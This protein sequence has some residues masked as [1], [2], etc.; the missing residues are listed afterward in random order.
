MTIKTA[1]YLN[2]FAFAANLLITYLSMTEIFGETNAQVSKKYQTLITPAGWAFSI[3]GIIFLSE[4]VFAVVQMFPKYRNNPLASSR[5]VVG[6]WVFACVFQISW[7]FA[8]AQEA[9]VLSCLILAL[10]WV[11]LGYVVL[12]QEAIL[13]DPKNTP[14]TPVDHVLLV[15]P[16]RIH[17]AW[18][19]AATA[20][21]FN[22]IPVKHA[23]ENPTLQLAVAIASL[24]ALAML[25]GLLHTNHTL[26][27]V[28]S[29]AI[30]AVASELA[31]PMEKISTMFG[32]VVVKGVKEASAVVAVLLAVFTVLCLLWGSFGRRRYEMNGSYVT[33][34]I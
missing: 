19:T 34:L 8:F 26:S 23:P 2:L 15:T 33:P 5:S 16:F 11:S 4:G 22:L 31:H 21:S 7:T 9:I 25:A 14:A 24:V 28:L 1:N 30:G 3:W 32:D 18:V 17:F 29:W 20:V 13:A 12:A 6:G 10:I 27:A